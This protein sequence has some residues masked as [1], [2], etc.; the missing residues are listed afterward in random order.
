MKYIQTT[1]ISNQP[2]SP[3]F[4]QHYYKQKCLTTEDIL[5]AILD[6]DSESNVEKESYDDDGAIAGA[7]RDSDNERHLVFTYLTATM[8]LMGKLFSCLILEKLCCKYSF[9]L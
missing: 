4:M 1:V 2:E 7:I 9:T 6:S 8:L 3:F 5:S